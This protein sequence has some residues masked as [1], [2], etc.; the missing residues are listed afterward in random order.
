M[1]FVR[2]RSSSFQM[3]IKEPAQLSKME[4]RFRRIRRHMVLRVRHAL[5]DDQI[6][7][8]SP[9]SATWAGSL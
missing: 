6:G 8:V 7:H 5:K 1:S 4:S 9:M 3:S 2:K